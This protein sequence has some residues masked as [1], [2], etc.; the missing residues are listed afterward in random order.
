MAEYVIVV[1]EEDEEAREGCVYVLQPRTPFLSKRKESAF[2]KSAGEEVTEAV[3]A[4]GLPFEAAMLFLKKAR[5]ASGKRVSLC[6]LALGEENKEGWRVL[7]APSK[8]GETASPM[9]EDEKLHFEE[10]RLLAEEIAKR[11][12]DA[13]PDMEDEIISVDEFEDILRGDCPD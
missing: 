9:T 12:R 3:V 4:A 8:G 13:I 2:W 1:Q 7:T 10:A 6:S 11:N 5:R